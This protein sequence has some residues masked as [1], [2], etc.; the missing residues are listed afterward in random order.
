MLV[1]FALETSDGVRRARAKLT[2]KNVDLIVLNDPHAIGR[3]TNH[4]TLV[5]ART[6]RRLSEMPK[7]A[8]AE[9]VLARVIELREAASE[10][11]GARAAR[12]A[13]PGVKPRTRRR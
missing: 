4:V 1:G 13:K 11:P 9:A 5:E 8:V 10:R 6:A 2:D 7:R 12:R 3:D